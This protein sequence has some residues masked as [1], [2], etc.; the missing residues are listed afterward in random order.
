MRN[1]LRKI[2]ETAKLSQAQVAAMAGISQNYYSTI[3]SGT[4]GNPLN[5][6]VAKRIASALGFEWTRFYEED[7]DR[8]EG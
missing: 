1:W 5:V 3:E 7:D 6:D 8:K 2:R 4:R